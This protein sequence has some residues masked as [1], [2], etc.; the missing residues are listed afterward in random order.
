MSLLAAAGLATL[1]RALGA[2]VI[3]AGACFWSTFP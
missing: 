3:A 2:A 1:W